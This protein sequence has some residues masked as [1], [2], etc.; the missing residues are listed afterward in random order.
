MYDT[1]YTY[2]Y[3]LLRDYTI[4]AYTTLL[5]YYI[6][7]GLQMVSIIIVIRCNNIFRYYTV[8]NTISIITVY[9]NVLQSSDYTNIIKSNK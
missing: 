3:L 2:M 7:Y 8:Y 6:T 1:H 5:S 9:I 4:I